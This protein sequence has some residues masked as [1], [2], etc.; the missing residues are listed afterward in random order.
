MQERGQRGCVCVCVCVCVCFETE[1]RDDGVPGAFRLL[2]SLLLRKLLADKTDRLLMLGLPPPVVAL[3][4]SRFSSFKSLFFL[5]LP[6]LSNRLISVHWEG[7]AFPPSRLCEVKICSGGEELDSKGLMN[8]SRSRGRYSAAQYRR[9]RRTVRSL[10]AHAYPAQ[11]LRK[12]MT[13]KA[14]DRIHAGRSL[15]GSRDTKPAPRT[16]SQVKPCSP[17][18][19]GRP[20]HES[21]SVSPFLAD[22]SFVLARP[23]FSTYSSAVFNTTLKHLRTSILFAGHGNGR[24]HNILPVAQTG[25][26]IRIALNHTHQGPFPFRRFLACP[27]PHL[28]DDLACGYLTR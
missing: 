20:C 23:F 17:F 7:V 13:C 24:Q 11:C 27:H 28:L 19:I 14:A 25:P 15:D 16:E 9:R 5:S 4:D 22:A 2:L 1:R 12:L 10:Q 21:M 3:V 6:P 18:F 8:G 26:R